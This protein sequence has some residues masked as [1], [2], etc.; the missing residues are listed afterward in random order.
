MYE[1]R[2]N[3][4]RV[5]RMISKP[6]KDLK[7]RYILKNN[8]TNFTMPIQRTILPWFI[9][10]GVLIGGGALAL[11]IN[12]YKKKKVIDKIKSA[13][14]NADYDKNAANTNTNT[15]ANIGHFIVKE[16]G[17]RHHIYP[18]RELGNYV[19]NISK[20]LN[21]YQN[22]LDMCAYKDKACKKIIQEEFKKIEMLKCCF[23]IQLDEKGHYLKNKDSL[24][25][26][27]SLFFCGINSNYRSD[28]PKD[29]EEPKCPQ[30]GDKNRFNRAINFGRK[31]KE[32]S[33]DLEQLGSKGYVD[34]NK[35]KSAKNSYSEMIANG[36]SRWLTSTIQN[37][38][39]K[40][41]KGKW[42]EKNSKYSLV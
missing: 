36:E 42:G 39:W 8:S 26:S 3:K 41:T 14:K 12:Y 18:R 4:K 21:T 1:A 35:I 33:D 32:M 15:H 9:A 13:Y 19:V 10:G 20:T 31:M 34:I 27:E 22:A 37:H 28:D 25:W 5:C 24:Y 38:D 40:L 17:T 16:N 2:Q 23:G 6:K 11:A 29:N 30:N 7:Q